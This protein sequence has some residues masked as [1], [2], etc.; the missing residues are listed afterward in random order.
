MT[1]V[2]CAPLADGL[3]Q[4]ASVNSVYGTTS[5]PATF[6]TWQ[7]FAAGQQALTTYAASIGPNAVVSAWTGL[8]RF[9]A[10][11]SPADAS[12][13]HT[14]MWSNSLGFVGQ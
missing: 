12:A 5:Q 4:C 3:T 14:I 13:T 11:A 1:A 2:A 9:A 10:P 7:E 8:Y 6:A